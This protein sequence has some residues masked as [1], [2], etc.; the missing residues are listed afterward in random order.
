MLGLAVMPGR[1]GR[2]T[3]IAEVGA[4][5]AAGRASA[6]AGVAR[7]ASVGAVADWL[8]EGWLG[9]AGRLTPIADAGGVLGAKLG[10][11]TGDG[12]LASLGSDGRV[13]PIELAG[14]GAGATR[15]GLGAAGAGLAGRETGAELVVEE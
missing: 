14:A 9:S 10:V 15:D 8:M 2:L 5:I 1:A 6:G 12:R 13:T 4:G 11:M 3:P 7:G